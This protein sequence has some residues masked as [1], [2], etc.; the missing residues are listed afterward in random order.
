MYTV[1]T[2]MERLAK[3]SKYFYRFCIGYFGLAIALTGILSC[4]GNLD[5]AI[6]VGV[7]LLVVGLLFITPYYTLK[8]TWIKAY[9]VLLVV[10]VCSAFYGLN[11]RVNSFIPAPASLPTP[12]DTQGPF[13]DGALAV[14]QSS[15]S[16]L[17]FGGLIFL[18]VAAS[19]LIKKPR[20]G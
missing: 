14:Y 4:I 18:D 16:F 5:A 8:G 17:F 2:I 19:R 15:G 13:A 9:V 11:H 12:A 6:R 1:H 7:P 20:A 3:L 10:A